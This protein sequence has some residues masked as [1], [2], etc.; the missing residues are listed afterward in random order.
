MSDITED[1][2]KYLMCTKL[3]LYFFLVN[4]LY[5]FVALAISRHILKA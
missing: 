2:V 4:A 3:Q 5:S 1:E